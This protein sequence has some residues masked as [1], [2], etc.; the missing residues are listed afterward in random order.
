MGV[1]IGLIPSCW[2]S[3]CLLNFLKAVRFVFSVAGK[4][5]PC[6]RLLQRLHQEQCSWSMHPCVFGKLPTWNLRS[7]WHMQLWN[8]I[9]WSYVQ[10]L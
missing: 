8:G 6:R 2:F 5:T 1:L 10:R 4:D 7:T 3:I 9:R